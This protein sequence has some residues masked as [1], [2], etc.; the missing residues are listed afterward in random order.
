[1][2]AGAQGT[3]LAV[4]DHDPARWKALAVL[5]A[6]QL[7]GMAPWFVGNA[8]APQLAEGWSLGPAEVGWLTSAVQ[9]GFVAG[10]FLAAI[11]NLADIVSGRILVSTCAVG[12][13]ACN[14]ALVVVPTYPAA[15]AARFLTGMFLA[16]VYPPAMKMVA[17][18]FRSARGLAIGALIGALTMGKALPYLLRAGDALPWPVVVLAVSAGSAAGA[19]LLLLAYREGP[20][21]FPR[22]PFS[23]ALAGAVVAHRETRLAVF[24]YLGHMWE[25]YAMWTW[26]PAFLAAS[27]IARGAAGE[28]AAAGASVLAFATI[29]IGA[30]GCL[31]G[32]WMADRIGRERL[33]S[34]AMAASG[35]CA[36]VIGLFFG[37]HPLLLLPIAAVWGFF[38]VADSAQFSALVTEVAPPH[39]VGTALALQTSIGFLLTTAT[40]QLVPLIAERAGWQWAFPVLAAGPVAGIAA[41]ARLRRDRADLS[42]AVHAAVLGPDDETAAG[43]GR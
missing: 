23:W 27:A 14:A 16:G 35:G 10:T 26:L 7:L 19:L 9:L 42:Q 38:V 20:F 34:L 22:R 43:D 30:A 29:G 31:W 6:S 15:L 18:W 13:A 5:C 17:T 41:I 12:A 37:G 8:V 24:G 11:L 32:G 3:P 39:A 33:V 21:A 25:L 28:A 2:G 40:I 36:L 4:P 1:M